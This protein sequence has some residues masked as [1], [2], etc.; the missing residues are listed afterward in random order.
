[1][2]CHFRQLLRLIFKGWPEVF[3]EYMATVKIFETFLNVLLGLHFPECQN[4]S[5]HEPLGPGSST[6]PK[7]VSA[8]SWFALIELR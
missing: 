7:L 6:V 1:M 5:F 4:I 8:S 2:E 3:S